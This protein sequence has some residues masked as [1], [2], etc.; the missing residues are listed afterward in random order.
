MRS[1]KEVDARNMPS[2][3]VTTIRKIVTDESSSMLPS[4][5]T[6]KGSAD[7]YTYKIIIDDGTKHLVLECSQYDLTDEMKSLVNYV[8]KFAVKK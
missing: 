4:K 3:I 6:L 5:T 2:S 1:S 8:E 7:H